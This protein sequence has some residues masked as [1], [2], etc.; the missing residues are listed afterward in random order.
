MDVISEQT[1]N[2]VAAAGGFLLTFAARQ[3]TMIEITATGTL[4]DINNSM[5]RCLPC[6]DHHE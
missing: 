2:G 4:E 1:P 5:W 3:A 6:G